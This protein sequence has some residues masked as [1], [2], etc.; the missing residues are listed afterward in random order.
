MIGLDAH[1]LEAAGGNRTYVLGLLRGLARLPA[2]EPGVWG[3]SFDPADAAALAPPGGMLRGHRLLAPRAAW[4]RVV[5]GAPALALRDGLRVWHASWV[6]PPWSSARLVLTV[7][8]LLWLSQPELFPRL[9]TARLRLLLPRALASASR[10]VVTSQ[11]TE[12]A[13]LAAFPRLPRRRVVH[14]PLGIDLARFHPERDPADPARRAALGVGP[15][16][17]VL[18]VGRP[19][20]R[21]GWDLLIQAAAAARSAP[22]V[23]LAG[24]HGGQ[25]GQFVSAA[26]EAGLP[27]ARLAVVSDPDEAGL[28]ALFRGARALCFPTRGEGVGLPALEALATGTPALLSDLP[29]LREAAGPAATY[30]APQDPLAWAGAIDRALGDPEVAERARAFG[31]PRVADRGLEAMAAATHEVYRAA[32]AEA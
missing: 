5:L 18:G 16:P 29:A 22:R 19:D 32:L 3:Y 20:P 24:P 11:A 1:Y 27:P 15:D 9:L 4:A 12:Q 23:V 10:V 8:D 21:K 2:A 17:Y 14:V 6:A 26:R 31:P 13:L 28:A 30:L 7:H 25:V